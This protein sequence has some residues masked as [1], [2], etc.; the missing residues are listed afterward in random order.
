MRVGIFTESYDPIINGVSTSV[1]TLTAELL[2]MGHTPIIVAPRYPG[3]GVATHSLPAFRDGDSLPCEVIRLP[4]W[5]TPFNP[6]NPFAFPPGVITP[7]EMRGLALDIVHTQQPFG[8]GLH[9]RAR[10]QHL[11]VPLISTFHTLYI[12]YTHYFR[13]VPR[14]VAVAYL[15]AVMQQYYRSCSAI[16][17]PSHEAGR[18]LERMG[19]RSDLL[20][21]IPT[22]VPAAA[23]VLQEAVERERETLS[24]PPCAP[25]LLFV[26]RVAPEK[27]LD[28]LIDSFTRLC[29]LP[30]C[31]SSPPDRHPLLLIVGNGPYV[32]ALRRR[33]AASGFGKWVRFAGFLTREQLAPVYRASTLFC[34]PSLTETQGV[35]LSE[36]QSYGLPCVVASGGGAPEFVRPDVDAL[37][38]P[39]DIHAFT[40]AIRSLLDDPARR[41]QFA[42]AARESPLRPAPTEMAAKVIGLYDAVLASAAR[43]PRRGA[44]HVG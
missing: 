21:V 18:R 42:R 32:E 37:V 43:R 9:G 38:V 36:A 40:E 5:R 10:A 20:H 23:P 31:Q 16:V 1:K 12:E 3:T 13:V 39:N 4:S 22:G 28:L 8:M 34:F 11:G 2:R 44:A 35:V 33:V 19:I 30:T 41:E 24:L 27:N 25:V 6:E 17:V 7:P 14:P 29:A 26:G 15:T